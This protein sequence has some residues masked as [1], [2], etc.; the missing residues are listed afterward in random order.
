MS[1]GWYQELQSPPWAP[2]PSTQ[3]F[4][5]KGLEPLCAAQ[6]F[7]FY[8]QPCFTAVRILDMSF[9]WHDKY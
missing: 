3:S 4:L 1:T 2:P 6:H 7:T 8:F 9:F 5:P